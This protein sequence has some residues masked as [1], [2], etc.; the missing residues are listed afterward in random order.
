MTVRFLSARQSIIHTDWLPSG[1]F[2]VYMIFS[3][4]TNFWMPVYFSEILGFS[5][6]QIGLLF[7]L[8]AVTGMLAA[9]PVGLGNDRAGSRQW[10]LLALGAQ[11][12]TM[13]LLG[14]VRLFLPALIV[15]FCWSLTF[16]LFRI[17]LETQLLKTDDGRATGRRVGVFVA[18][19]YG[20]LGLGAILAGYLLAALGF[21]TTFQ[22]IAAV[23]LL[24]LVPASLLPPTALAESRLTDYLRDLKNPR[25]WPFIGVMFLFA[26]HWG[27]EYTCYSLFLKCGLGLSLSRMGWYMA[28]E[29]ASFV[30]IGFLVAPRLTAGAPLKKYL[31]AALF[32]SGLG[33]VGMV[34]PRLPVSALFRMLH[35]AGDALMMVLLYVGIARLFDIHRRGGNAGAV[36]LAMMLG[37][38]LGAL[39][40]GP[41]GERFGYGVPIWLGGL[42]L[43]LPVP[44]LFLSPRRGAA[45][46]AS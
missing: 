1:I 4:V 45:P 31:A 21:H 17:S 29:F 24:L 26:V 43:A 28:L 6:A 10:V 27:S 3:A 15:F 13:I 34:D 2:G 22:L 23:T 25:V 32:A 12:A 42:L 30:L 40:A 18:L 19:R 33:L 7:A 11:A 46:S 36:N 38:I 9:F 5:G 8:N 16:S 35:G 14:E 44:F 39:V 20:G 41:L 37:L